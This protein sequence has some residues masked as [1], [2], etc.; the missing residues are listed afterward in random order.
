MYAVKITYFLENGRYFTE[1]TYATEKHQL[2]LIWKEIEEK[3]ITNENRPG[4]RLYKGKLFHALVEV[5]NHE[6]N[7]PYLIANV[8]RLYK[9][10]QPERIKP[11]IPPKI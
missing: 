9:R 8:S 1:G 3:I 11:W 7:R 6:Y 4:F 5:P 2:S 10:I